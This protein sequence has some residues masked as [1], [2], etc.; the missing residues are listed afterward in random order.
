MG[1]IRLSFLWLFAAAAAY[2]DLRYRKVP[3]WL[4]LCA[5]SGGVIISLVGGWSDLRYG[6]CG[7]VLGLLLLL[8]AF[9]LHMVGGGDVKSLAVI[10]LFVG[11]HLLWVSFLLGAAVGGM[12]ALFILAARYLPRTRRSSGGERRFIPQKAGA[13]TLPYAG[14]L[15]VCAA[16]YALLSSSLG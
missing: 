5:L 9:V 16:L 1:P 3:N 11:P 14:I 8:P 6:L 12:L 2:L 15:S 7:F 10:G 4:I 13:W